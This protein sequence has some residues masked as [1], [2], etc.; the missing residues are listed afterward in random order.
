M[1]ANLWGEHYGLSPRGALLMAALLIGPEQREA[2]ASLRDAAARVP[3]DIR[4]LLARV[5]IPEGKEAHV[6]HMTA[7]TIELPVGYLVTFSI[8]TGHPCGVARHL[9]MSTRAE[10]KGPLPEAVWMVA[11]ELGF[12]GGLD[13][14]A[15]G[16]G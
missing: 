12:A 5:A 7:Q 15:P 3:V 14:G 6:A 4:T 8:E 10:G 16:R 11:Q 13:V 9:S 1:G 2:L